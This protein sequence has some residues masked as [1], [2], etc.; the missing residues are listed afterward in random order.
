M[1]PFF[2]AGLKAVRDINAAIDGGNAKE[3]ILALNRSDAKLP[4]VDTQWAGLYQEELSGL[5]ATNEAVRTVLVAAYTVKGKT[6]SV[7]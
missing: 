5:K 2:G 6:E 7:A 4:P 3:T 1:C